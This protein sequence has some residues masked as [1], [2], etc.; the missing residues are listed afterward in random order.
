V[1]KRFPSLQL[2]FFNCR[3]IAGTN[4]WS[5]HAYWN[6]VDI[7]TPTVAVGRTVW[8]WLHSTYGTDPKAPPFPGRLLR[9]QQPNMTGGDVHMW[10]TQ[11]NARLGNNRSNPLYI[12]ADGVFGPATDK[13]TRNFQSNNHLTVDGIVGPNTWAKAW[14]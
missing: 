2:E 11:M 5:Q 14:G 9:L 6:A 4:D 7:M 13:R 8:G 3:D 1:R 10:Q 12:T